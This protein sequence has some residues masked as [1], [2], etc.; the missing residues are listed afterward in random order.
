MN[1]LTGPG[2]EVTEV[3]MKSFSGVGGSFFE[4]PRGVEERAREASRS[5]GGSEAVRLEKSEAFQPAG[6]GGGVAD[7]RVV[8]DAVRLASCESSMGAVMDQWAVI[9]GVW[10]EDGRVS[11]L[12]GRALAIMR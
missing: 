8:F 6:R 3:E 2:R 1:M 12:E 5:D 10:R 4:L 11:E 7:V 9:W